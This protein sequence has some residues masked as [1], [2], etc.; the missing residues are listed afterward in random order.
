LS[1]IKILIA[2]DEAY[3]RDELKHILSSIPEIE[4]V[5]EAKNGLEAVKMAEE[6][7]PDIIFMDIEMP[8]LT[9]MEAAKKIV[10]KNIGAHLIFATAYDEYAL[11]AFEVSAIDYILKP[12]EEERIKRSVQ[13]AQALIKKA[14]IPDMERISKLIETISGGK[15]KYPRKISVKYKGKIN[16]LDTS[17]IV[18]A[19]G[20]GGL[21][22]ICEGEKEYLSDY[23]SLDNLEKELDPE[24]FHRTH[25]SYIV[26]LDKMKQILPLG[27]GH[28]V[29]RCKMGPDQLLDIP[30]SRR[31]AKE[32]RKKIN[33]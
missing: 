18:Y 27:A 2:D 20:E 30:L 26:N 31:Q 32:L 10:E 14:S 28:Y 11:K 15:A 17:E 7:G 4:V 19:K 1:K 22:Y 25:R 9:G 5:G 29:I 13:K 3:A 33:F 21:V 24:K 8:G 23:S 12:F 16:L 6:K